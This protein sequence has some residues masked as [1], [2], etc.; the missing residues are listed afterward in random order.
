MPRQEPPKADWRMGIG[1]NVF[2]GETELGVIGPVPR[3][4]TEG[5]EKLMPQS[6]L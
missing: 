6:P 3:R 4:Q 1:Y 2:L 5:H